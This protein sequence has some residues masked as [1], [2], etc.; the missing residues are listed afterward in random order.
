MDDLARLLDVRR[1]DREWLLISQHVAAGTLTRLLE[2]REPLSLGELVTLISPLAQAL[3]ILHRAGLTHGN[4]TLDIGHE[5]LPAT[6]LY[7]GR[8]LEVSAGGRSRRATF[9]GTFADVPAGDLLLYEDGSRM[10]ALA[11][12]RGDAATELVLRTDSEVRLTPL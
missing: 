10:L 7:Y 6:G 11:V 4:V 12:N 2:R 3:A 1:T 9:A 8:A 5:D